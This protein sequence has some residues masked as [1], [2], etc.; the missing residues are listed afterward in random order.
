MRTTQIAGAA[1]IAALGLSPSLAWAQT[2][3]ITRTE[4]QKIEALH[5]GHRVESYLVT[6]APHGLV[7]RHTHPGVEIGYLIS[8]G[9]TL[10]V[11]G[12]PE[13]TVKSGD[14]WA[15]PT[16]IPHFLLNTGDRPEQLVVT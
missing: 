6:V 3:P 7:A 15:I 12:Q 10:S 5:A 16:G 9:S 14:S 13:R 8:G 2:S 4:L 1:M 11:Q